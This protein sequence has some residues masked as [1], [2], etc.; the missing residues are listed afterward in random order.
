MQTS[1]WPVSL[2]QESV[3]QKKTKTSIFSGVSACAIHCLLIHL[4]CANVDVAHL[5]KN[6]CFSQIIISQIDALLVRGC[7]DR[8][9]RRLLKTIDA[10]L[11]VR[12]DIWCVINFSNKILLQIQ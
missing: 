10:S 3:V 1:P 12:G 4:V 8:W 5:E 2:N 9:P 11:L 7:D 6:K